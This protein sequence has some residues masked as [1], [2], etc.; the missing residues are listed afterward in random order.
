MPKNVDDASFSSKQNLSNHISNHEGNLT[1]K[2]FECEICLKRFKYW[3]KL[4]KHVDSVHEKI[5]PYQCDI[6]EKRFSTNCSMVNHKTSVHAKERP[7]Q[8]QLCEL[9][10][11]A[12]TSLRNHIRAVHDGKKPFSC[13]FCE[14]TTA[15]KY[16]LK[17]HVASVHNGV[18]FLCDICDI[19]FT[20]KRNLKRHITK[21]HDEKN[22]FKTS[23]FNYSENKNFEINNQRG[24][25]VY[26]WEY[27]PGS[28]LYI[29]YNLLNTLLNLTKTKS[30][31]QKIKYN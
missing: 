11:S 19:K 23:S 16:S 25:F 7:F 1:E 24:T 20:A 12:N 26:R 4:K 6:C 30:I 2:S 27:Q 21:V 18:K 3:G 10:F 28:L 5:K 8:C 14:H 15:H 13:S 9:G 17:D 22:S 29:V 31:D